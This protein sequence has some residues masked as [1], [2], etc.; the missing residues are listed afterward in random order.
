MKT[1]FLYCE[2]WELKKKLNLDHSKSLFISGLAIINAPFS[3]YAPFPPPLQAWEKGW[4]S[5]VFTSVA[6][7]W[8]MILKKL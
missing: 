4:K 2:L 1:F 7:P 3:T 8:W 6:C 5:R